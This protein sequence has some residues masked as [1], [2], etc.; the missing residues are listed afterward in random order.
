MQKRLIV[1][2]AVLACLAAAAWVASP[3][4]DGGVRVQAGGAEPT[5]PTTAPPTTQ[6]PVTTSTTEAPTTTMA[7]TTTTTTVVVTTTSTTEEPVASTHPATTA[8]H[9]PTTEPA[10]HPADISGPVQDAPI[11]ANRVA[12]VCTTDEQY[13]NPPTTPPR[14][15]WRFCE[16]WHELA[17]EVGW[18]ESAGYMLSGVIYYESG[19]NPN[20]HN[21][22]GATGLMQLLGKHCTPDLGCFMPSFDPATNLAQGLSLYRAEG[23]WR[24][25]WCGDRAVGRC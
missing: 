15:P 7:P 9:A 17:A 12:T 13:C 11:P 2:L 5:E 21:P 19:C 23:G 20:A 4:D 16:E 22:S 25:A 24:P 8:A 3:K 14:Q 10:L 6:T 18:P 1:L